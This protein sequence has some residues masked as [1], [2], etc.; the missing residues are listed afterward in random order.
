MPTSSSHFL[1]KDHR[2]LIEQAE[3]AMHE[4]SDTIQSAM[5]KASR[6][7]GPLPADIG[8]LYE[9]PLWSAIE[10]SIRFWCVCRRFREEL[11]GEEPMS[12]EEAYRMFRE[13]DWKLYIATM[14]DPI[15]EME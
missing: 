3:L 4:T 1:E 11:L 13:W 12:T 14:P 15:K 2:R 10:E 6:P 8:D 5:V 9:T 7:I